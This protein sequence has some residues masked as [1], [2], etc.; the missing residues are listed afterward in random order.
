MTGDPGAER[1][2]KL[3]VHHAG[4]SIERWSAGR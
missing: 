4:T 2:I 3:F 1:D